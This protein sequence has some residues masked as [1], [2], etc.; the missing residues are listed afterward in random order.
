[1]FYQNKTCSQ[2]R[3][4]WDPFRFNDKGSAKAFHESVCFMRWL[5]SD[6][7]KI[8]KKFSKKWCHFLLVI[9]KNFPLKMQLEEWFQPSKRIPVLLFL[10]RLETG[11]SGNLL[12]ACFFPVSW[13]LLG[14]GSIS[15]LRHLPCRHG[16]T[17][18]LLVSLRH[19]GVPIFC[20]FPEDT[21]NKFLRIKGWLCPPSLSEVS[22]S[23]SFL[24]LS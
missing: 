20:D 15:Y 4:L 8:G 18:T 1:M 22:S 21:P 19:Y 14:V 24:S 10:K 3:V 6:N 13:K 9:C 23:L 7:T 16:G 17:D 5:Y 11:R 12:S 2:V